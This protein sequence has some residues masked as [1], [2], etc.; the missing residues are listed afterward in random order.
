MKT[1]PSCLECGQP[2]SRGVH[3]FS[4]RI[5]GHSLCM[6]DMFNIDE[7]GATAQVIDLYLAL[8]AR[9]F[10]VM[11]EYWD[12]HK[13]VDIALPGKLYIEINGPTHNNNS[14]IMSDL[15]RAIFSLEKNIPTIIIPNSMLENAKL[16]DHA[17]NEISK[18]CRMVL[19]RPVVTGMKLSFSREQM[20]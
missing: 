18:A 15:T 14:Q 16:F 20:Q 11:L 10:P 5:Y 8:K 7:S 3:L 13:H 1:I 2:L 19:K 6:K 4:R 12:E 9:S 17:V